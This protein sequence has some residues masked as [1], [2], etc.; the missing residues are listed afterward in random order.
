VT[1]TM[2]REEDTVH[3]LIGKGMVMSQQC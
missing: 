3:V 1:I 2:Y